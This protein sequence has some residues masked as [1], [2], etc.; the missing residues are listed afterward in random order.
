MTFSY[1]LRR[2]CSNIPIL[3]ESKTFSS[4]MSLIHLWNGAVKVEKSQ[5]CQ[6]SNAP[7]PGLWWRRPGA[8]RRCWACQLRACQQRRRS[9][10]RGRWGRREAGR[11]GRTAGT[12]LTWTEWLWVGGVRVTFVILDPD[13]SHYDIIFQILKIRGS[14]WMIWTFLVLYYA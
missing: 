8:G 7:T 14:K 11:P 13:S 6:L 3:A 12:P 2:L 4:A 10:W 9:G 1:T 5:F